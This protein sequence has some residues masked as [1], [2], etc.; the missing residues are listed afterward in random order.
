MRKAENEKPGITFLNER[1]FSSRELLEGLDTQHQQLISV[2]E[3]LTLMQP[4]V[5]VAINT[6][7]PIRL[8]PL[9]DTHLFSRYTDLEAVRQTLHL[10]D[11]ENTFGFITGDFIEGVCRAFLTIRVSGT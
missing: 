5:E 1:G 3:Q 2:N 11:E 9:G 10:L 8:V 4:E 6:R 7:G